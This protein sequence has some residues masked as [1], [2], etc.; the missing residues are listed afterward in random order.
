MKHP[1]A[2][3]PPTAGD[4]TQLGQ[5]D[6]TDGVGFLIRKNNTWAMFDGTGPAALSR[7]E[8]TG[9]LGTLGIDGQG[10]YHVRAD[11][12]VTGFNGTSPVDVSIYVDD[13]LVHSFSTDFGFTNNF[14][15]LG[16]RGDNGSA[17]GLT[18]HAFDN[19]AVYTSRIPEPGTIVL[20]LLG[21]LALAL[22]R[23]R[24]RR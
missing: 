18:S 20:L 7:V 9:D 22:F 1:S 15:V 17:A 16:S 11:Y 2:T 23:G 24:R 6:T 4:S 5:V 3:F 8:A 12:S 21:G 14:L 10:F 13:L 19:L